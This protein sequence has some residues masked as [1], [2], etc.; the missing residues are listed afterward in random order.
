M[1]A[2]IGAFD[3]DNDGDDDLILCSAELPLKLYRNDGNFRFSDI[4]E[5]A[6][7]ILDYHVCVTAAADLDNDDW[8]DLILGTLVGEPNLLLKNNGNGT[9]N[10]I[11][12]DAGVTNNKQWAAAITIGDLNHDSFLDFYIG[13]NATELVGNYNPSHNSVPAT[14]ELFLSQANPFD[15]K[16]VALEMSVAGNG[17][18]WSTMFVNFDNDDDLDL[19]VVNDLGTVGFEINQYYEN[20]GGTFTERGSDYGLDKAIFGMGI[21]YGDYDN[22][23]D[24]DFY[25]SDIDNNDF[26]ENEN[27]NFV[28]VTEQTY[29][30][31]N[32]VSWG[33]QFSD[34]TND[35]LLDILMSNSPVFDVTES[36]PFI[37][38][39]NLGSVFLETQIPIVDYPFFTRGFTLS[40]FDNDGD[41]DVIVSVLTT[42]TGEE[43]PE[44]KITVFE[45]TS[46]LRYN[47]NNFLQVR[48][49]YTE[50]NRDA[51]G[52]KI[53]LHLSDGTI[54]CRYLIIG[55]GFTSFNSKVVHFGL[56]NRTVDMLKVVWPNSTEEKT[57]INIPINAQISV[58]DINDE[59][60]IF[61]QTHILSSGQKTNANLIS[62]LSK[63]VSDYL[64]LKI[65]KR[66]KYKNIDYQI[67]TLSGQR[68][69]K[70]AFFSHSNQMKV[71]LPHSIG[72]G[73]YLINFN[74]EYGVI[75]KKFIVN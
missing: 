29:A 33:G 2:G 56:G 65:G 35:G 25:L 3:F 6:G 44:N 46:D 28:D 11:S 75:K 23:Q 16:E 34:L 1:M 4:T 21:G 22:D 73:V 57:F 47:K 38:Y 54:L 37:Y 50:G 72:S 74:T 51:M 24:F 9:F 43:L 42:E 8:Q 39:E 19:Y 27:N 26:L 63:Q 12:E 18:T 62:V 66:L 71:A 40:D 53:L 48:L 59:I 68:L 41:S 69:A 64:S 14:N 45:N 17:F 20:N 55:G 52:S 15:Y 60:E 67:F 30:I 58:N 13:N 7:L 70:G 36:Q 5:E 61:R 49:S 10:D 32:F 31:G